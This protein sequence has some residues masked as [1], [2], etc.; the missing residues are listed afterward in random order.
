VHGHGKPRLHA[1]ALTQATARSFSDLKP[2]L[3]N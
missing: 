1:A 3:I 2:G